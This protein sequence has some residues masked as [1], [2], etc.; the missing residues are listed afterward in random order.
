MTRSGILILLLISIIAAV[1]IYKRLIGDSMKKKSDLASLEFSCIKEQNPPLDKEAD[2]W[3]QQARRIERS[4]QPGT[5]KEVIELYEKAVAKDHYKAINNLATIYIMGDIVE[6]DHHRVLKLAEQGMQ[7]ESPMAYYAMGVNLEHGIGVKQDNPASL[8][9]FRK[10]ADMGYPPGQYAVG[11]ILL[12]DFRQTPDA[13]RI[14]GIGI[15]MLECS[16]EQGYAQAGIELGYYFTTRDDH[17]ERG[18]VYFQK[19]AALGDS[20]ALYA[21]LS[22]FED[23][24]EGAPQDP[25]R[26]A[27]YDILWNEYKADRK[28]TF[29]DIDQRCP[30]P[31]WFYTGKKP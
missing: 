17:K 18:L 24:T 3:F 16:L 20:D 1:F 28:K 7:L 15:Q 2:E 25:E 9:Y 10:S 5:A 12:G 13:E 8:A 11:E 4:E 22:A 23:G 14:M 31:E 6:T 27:C 29:P 30:L 21:L 26:A 19:A